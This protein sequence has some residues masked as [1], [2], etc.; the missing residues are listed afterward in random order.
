M[1]HE[2]W[3]SCD[4]S[5]APF[6]SSR[7]QHWIVFDLGRHYAVDSVHIWNYNLDTLT[8]T[9]LLSIYTLDTSAQ[10]NKI[11]QHHLDTLGL[12]SNYMGQGFKYDTTWTSRFVGIGIDSAYSTQDTCLG[13]SEIFFHEVVDTCQVEEPEVHLEFNYCEELY[14]AVIQNYTSYDVITRDS[15][16]LQDSLIVLSPGVNRLLFEQDSCQLIR[17]IEH[18]G[19]QGNDI[20][21]AISETIPRGKYF[22]DTIMTAGLVEQDAE[23][24][25]VSADESSLKNFFS[26]EEGSEFTILKDDCVNQPI[27][28]PI[29]YEE[30]QADQL[31]FREKNHIGLGTYSNVSVTSSSVE[32]PI[33]LLTGSSAITND[34][35]RRFLIQSTFGPDEDMVKQ[36][37]DL[38]MTD[39]LDWQLS[40]P[41]Q[42]Y[43]D[44][45]FFVERFGQP[46]ILYHTGFVRSWWHNILSGEEYLRDRVA[47]AL[48]QIFVISSK[49][50]LHNYGDGFVSYYNMLSDNAFSN[51]RDLL[52][53]V[54][55]H[56]MMGFYLSHLN[57]PKGDSTLN[58]FPDEN[59]AREI[60]QLF[61]IGL[62][63]LNQDGS[64]QLDSLDNPISTYDNDDI[65]EFAKIFT[66]LHLNNQAFGAPA[67]VEPNRLRR[68][69]MVHEMQM[70]KDMHSQG[71]KKLLRGVSTDSTNTAE[72]DIAEAID[73]IFNHPNVGPFVALRLIQRLVKSN[74]S[75]AYIS[76]VSEAFND[77]GHGV[78][79]DMKAV[80]RAIL[81]DEEARSCEARSSLTHGKLKEPILRITQLLKAFNVSSSTDKFYSLGALPAEVL[82]QEVMRAPSVFNFYLP[83]HTPPGVLSDSVAFAPE[84]QIFNSSTSCLLYTSPSPRDRTRSRMP[85]S[86]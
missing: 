12:G 85:S 53:E 21:F 2:S 82:Q 58:V 71:V 67:R 17:F 3:I 68:S 44:D 14:Y 29:E 19:T 47:Y 49:S 63:E 60:L 54:T 83:D 1:W 30:Y 52:E 70:D 32:D 61:S 18:P 34:E 66:G 31:K 76:R 5:I 80:I 75:P 20:P 57:N 64:L 65:I 43:L 69:A 15:T 7:S 37:V 59:Y 4:T 45:L 77:N 79:G 62:Y 46:N 26:V 56:P 41:H 55:Y 6:D 9:K 42:S 74:P 24:Y 33:R 13:L 35:I 27:I 48:S 72:E 78:R 84:F 22:K 11:G 86:A 50:F 39:W 81:L 8:R 51:Y 23:V 40:V 38:G 36:A 10:W 73:N 25:F 16:I 28:L